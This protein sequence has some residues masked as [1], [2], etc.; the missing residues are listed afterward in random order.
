[1]LPYTS[2]LGQ[3]WQMFGVLNLS[4]LVD[5]T[6]LLVSGVCQL[7]G[8]FHTV[9]QAH[10]VLLFSLQFSGNCFSFHIHR[11]QQNPPARLHRGGLHEFSNNRTI[12]LKLC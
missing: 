5:S 3:I 6:A 4:A 12:A 2:G 7:L 8:D 11:E 10:T 1:M 9:P